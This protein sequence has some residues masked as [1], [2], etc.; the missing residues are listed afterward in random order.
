MEIEQPEKEKLTPDEYREYL[1]AAWM[2]I[3]QLNVIPLRA[4]L[5]AQEHAE[6]IAPFMD[7]TAFREKGKQLRQD[8]LVTKM[9][10]TAQDSFR[11]MMREPK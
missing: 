5:A 3:N 4:M 6:T 9:L 7:P 8:I 1:I 11:K 10:L 2:T